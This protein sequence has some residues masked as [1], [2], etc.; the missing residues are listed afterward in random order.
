MMFLKIFG[1]TRL[2]VASV[3]IF[4]VSCSHQQLWC[5]KSVLAKAHLGLTRVCSHARSRLCSVLTSPVR[6]T[7]QSKAHSKS[8]LDPGV[9]RNT[10][11]ELFSGC[12]YLGQSSGIF[13]SCFAATE[14]FPQHCHGTSTDATS[15]WKWQCRGAVIRHVSLL[16]ATI[17]LCLA[18]NRLSRKGK[19]DITQINL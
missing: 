1:V 17:R 8:S 11:T 7:A 6:S 14:V 10:S 15:S 13:L 16:Q 5:G 4:Y 9:Q 12:P 18:Q 3:W 19:T 2:L